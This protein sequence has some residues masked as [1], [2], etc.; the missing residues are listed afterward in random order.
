MG[1]NCFILNIALCFRILNVIQ[2]ALIIVFLVRSSGDS[3]DSNEGRYLTP[4]QIQQ[5]QQALQDQQ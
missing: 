2:A 3:N 4:I 1:F 5:R